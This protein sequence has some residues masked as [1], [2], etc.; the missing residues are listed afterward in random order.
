MSDRQG[1]VACLW[2]QDEADEAIT[3]YRDVFGDV[4]V[5][6]ELRQGPGG[7]LITATIAVQGQRL[8]LLNG[9]RDGG[10]DD[11]VS[12]MV[13]CATQADVDRL[14]DAFV[15]GGGEPGRCGWLK[16][17]FGVA[18]QIVPDGLGAA[19]SDPDPARAQRAVQAMLGMSKLDLP[20]IARAAAG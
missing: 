10:F 9:R 18:W 11:S 1:L 19:L 17:R 13:P 3:H 6:H 7:P 14:W 4:S 8:M 15:A 12:L 16:D 20:A 2:F 5:V